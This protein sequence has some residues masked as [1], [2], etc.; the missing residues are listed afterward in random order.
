MIVQ[1]QPE[2]QMMFDFNALLR[3]ANG[4]QEPETPAPVR[5]VLDDD[6]GALLYDAA[7]MLADTLKYGGLLDAGVLRDAM[8]DAFGG[9][10]AQGLWIWRDAYEA[11]EAAAVMVLRQGLTPRHGLD[12]ILRVAALEP[13][14]T[15]RSDEQ[16]RLQQFSTPLPYAFAAVKAAG[17]RPDDT[18]LEPSAG[19]GALAVFAQVQLGGTRSLHLNEI[20][21][22]RAELLSR[23]FDDVDVTRCNAEQIR[24]RLPDLRP[25]VVVMNPPFSRSP[26]IQKIRHDADLRHIRSAYDAL[27]DGGRLVAITS[28]NCR[29]VGSDWQGAFDSI[30]VKPSLVFSSAVSGSVYARRGTTF[31][32]RLTVID[33]TTEPGIDFNPEQSAPD[34]QTLIGAVEEFCARKGIVQPPAKTIV[35]K[36]QPQPAPQPERPRVTVR[37][38][39]IIPTRTGVE[40]VPISA[41]SEGRTVNATPVA[42][43]LTNEKIEGSYMEWKPSMDIEGSSP[44]PTKLVQTSAM[45]AVRHPVP[46][47]N[48]MLPHRVIDE[49]LLSDAQLESVFLAGHAHNQLLPGKV[50]IGSHWEIVRRETEEVNPGV[51]ETGETLSGPVQFRQG[52]F[53]GDGT[54]AGKGRQAAGILA[55]NWL[56]G[57]KRALWLSQSDKLIED[58]R[59]DVEGLGGDPNMVFPLNKYPQSKPVAMP[60]GIMFCTYSTL[61][62]WGRNGNPSRLE[63]IV[64]WL[65]DGDTE[66]DR[67][68][69][70]GCIMF[71]EAHAMSNAAGMIAR[72]G[73]RGD[74]KPS[75][76]GLA[77]LRLQN[78]LPN[79]RVTY[80]SATGASTVEGLA[81]AV[82]LGLWGIASDTTPFHTRQHFVQAM[83]SGG[84][85]AMEVVARDLK[86]LGLYQARMLAYDGVEVDILQHDLT[87]DQ[88]D[89]YDVYAG[90]FKIIHK[91][92]RAAMEAVGITDGGKALNGQAMG[93]ALSKFEGMKQRF[94]GHLLNGMKCRT[95][96]QAIEKDLAEERSAVIQLVSTGESLM[97]RRLETIP[98]SEHNDLNVDLTPRDAVIEYLLHAFPTQLYE[99]YQ[100]DEGQARSRPVY[101]KDKNPVQSQHAVEM[102]DA[103]VE[104]LASLPPTPTAIDQLLHH[105]GDDAVAEVTGRSRRILALTDKT[106]DVRYALRRRPGSSNLAEAQSFMDGDKRI[107]IF[108]NA[109]GIGRSY[110]ADV[111][112]ANTQRRVHYLLETGWRADQAIQGLGRTHRTRQASAPLFRPVTTNVKGERRF[113]ATIARRLDSLGAIT[114]GQRNSQSDMGDGGRLFRES[115][116]LESPHAKNALRMFYTDLWQG[117]I[118]GWSAETFQEATGLN[119]VNGDGTLKEEL[120]PM[121]R[122]LNRVLALPI[123]EQNALFRELERRVDLLIEYA[124]EQGTFEVGVEVL[125]ADSL[126]IAKRET[127]WT[128]PKSGAKTELVEIIRKRLVK[129]LTV[130]EAREIAEDNGEAQYVMNMQS[131]RAAVCIP[132]SSLNSDG[133]IIPRIK[134]VRPNRTE[135]MPSYE[136][137]KSHWETVDEGVW[138]HQW[139]VNFDA[140]PTHETG[141]LWLAI[142]LLL[143]SWDKLRAEDVRV[144]RCITDDGQALIGRLFDVDEAAAARRA[145]GIESALDMT[146]GDV[147]GMVLEKG[148]HVMLANQYRLARRRIMGLERVEVEGPRYENP[149]FDLLVSLGCQKEVIEHR[150]RVFVPNPDVCQTLIT[151]WPIASTA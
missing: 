103:L 41:W 16:I 123:H 70:D 91:N 8:A 112:S 139:Q 83:E 136:F 95:L 131:G 67:H 39:R 149:D 88:T 98:P 104:R 75:A 134:L 62:Q 26:G 141:R 138:A 76:Q 4:G 140:L 30:A 52:W 79:A 43:P 56:R 51:M 55:D 94:F 36:A 11:A 13:S 142:G 148:T 35:P 3:E 6:K 126:R 107:L 50:Q 128:D 65:A 150:A 105:F 102:R 7:V 42:A 84:I 118:K 137:N 21:P 5:K 145:F 58:A 1:T 29:P 28:E 119:I 24:D 151:R 68:S 17:I 45:A 80:I 38:A 49:S 32:S 37:K 100:D 33:K 127:L 74:K 46:P 64:K 130:D 109:G 48:A 57:R 146:G 71:D 108:S 69:F 121:S 40:F 15:R 19:L 129:R 113:I 44:H 22:V 25:S 59:R 122:Y 87:D 73:S 97:E 47:Y 106:G 116:D 101:D 120:P 111:A 61:R 144:R 53:L 110:H 86:A 81:Y 66:A 34:V 93:A 72:K 99:E 12:A 63:Q 20:A 117:A 54:G 82:R 85:A 18:V 77:G 143:P 2:S 9:T 115:D 60:E 114:R 89:V 23:V 124:K 90:A 96:I 132:T 27:Q 31:D 14:Q 92:L 133:K 125:R 78:A 10:D 147:F 135:N